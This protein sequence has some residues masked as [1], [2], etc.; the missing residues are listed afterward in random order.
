MKSPSE[1]TSNWVVELGDVA[2]PIQSPKVNRRVSDAFNEW[3]AKSKGPMTQTE[4]QLEL[5]EMISQ[6]VGYKIDPLSIYPIHMGE[7]S[8]S[9]TDM[10]ELNVTFNYDKHQG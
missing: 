2:L 8:E 6:A 9:T 5:A 7:P 10:V 1:A 3:M 4:M